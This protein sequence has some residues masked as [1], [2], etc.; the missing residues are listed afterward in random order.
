MNKSIDYCRGA[1]IDFIDRGDIFDSNTT[2]DEVFQDSAFDSDD[3]LIYGEHKVAYSKINSFEINDNNCRI[4][5]DYVYLKLEYIL[6]RT[7]QVSM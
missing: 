3:V 2:I 1:W 5:K 7:E 6:R 4:M